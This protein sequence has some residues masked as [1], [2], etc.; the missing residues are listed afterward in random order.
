[1]LTQ[2]HLPFFTDAQNGTAGKELLKLV[3][4]HDAGGQ[5]MLLRLKLGQHGLD[6]H[7]SEV[8]PAPRETNKKKIAT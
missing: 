3:M 6:P 5:P 4:G 8:F 1:M 7:A 2:S